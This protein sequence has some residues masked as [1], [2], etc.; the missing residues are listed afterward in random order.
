MGGATGRS[1]VGWELGLK[2]ITVN[3]ALL[4]K[5]YGARLPRV[6][7]IMETHRDAVSLTWMIAGGGGNF[8]ATA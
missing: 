7:K 8:G 3:E 5:P 2:E 4:A 1:T 6:L